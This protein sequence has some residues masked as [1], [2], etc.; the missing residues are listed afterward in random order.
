[1]RQSELKATLR[2]AASRQAQA[3][4]LGTRGALLGA[5][6]GSLYGLLFA[7]LVALLGGAAGGVTETVQ[8]FASS[9]A[10]AGIL[11]GLFGAVIGEETDSPPDD[12]A[13]RT[14]MTARCVR[15]IDERVKGRRREPVNRL[16]SVSS[17]N[18]RRIESAAS[19]N[20][21]WN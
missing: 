13:R 4:R 16:A 21:S 12:S 18:R 14:E 1:M 20:P 8:Y 15:L 7:G 6:S 10:V 19:R 17:A 5:A 11:V 2:I 9:G 3:V